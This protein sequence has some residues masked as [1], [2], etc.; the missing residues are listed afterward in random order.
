MALSFRLVPPSLLC[1]LTYNPAAELC[2]LPTAPLL[3]PRGAALQPVSSF[4]SFW[5]C[6]ERWMALLINMQCRTM[7]AAVQQYETCMNRER[8]IAQAIYDEIKLLATQHCL[9]LGVIG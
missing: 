7:H 3:S 6:L 4:L 1:Y 5:S 8:G 2:E 9:S